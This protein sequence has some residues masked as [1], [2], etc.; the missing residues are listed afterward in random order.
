MRCLQMPLFQLYLLCKCSQKPKETNHCRLINFKST[1]KHAN[2]QANKQTWG[3]SAKFNCWIL[4]SLIHYLEPWVKGKNKKRL[5]SQAKK[6]TL[7]IIIPCYHHVM[8]TTRMATTL[9]QQK[10][11]HKHNKNDYYL[12]PI[13]THQYIIDTS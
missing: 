4:L 7:H 5:L 8:N 6:K 9:S 2:M 12:K 3:M 1:H 13:E 11:H 10:A